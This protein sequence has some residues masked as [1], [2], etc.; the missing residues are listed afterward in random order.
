MKQELRTRS[1]TVSHKQLNDYFI[2]YGKIEKEK[3]DS[4]EKVIA[5]ELN[6]VIKGKNIIVSNK[7]D[8]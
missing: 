7:S 6:R 1:Y 5:D 4:K 8:K 3:R 2:K